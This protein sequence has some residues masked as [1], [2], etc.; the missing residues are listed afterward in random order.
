MGMCENQLY[1]TGTNPTRT[2]VYVTQSI[3]VFRTLRRSQS[4]VFKPNPTFRVLLR[5]PS[6]KGCVMGPTIFGLLPKD[7]GHLSFG[8]A[9][10]PAQEGLPEVHQPELG[11]CIL[12]LWAGRGM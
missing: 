6:E 12:H 5:T 3:G 8:D 7:E 4:V 1:P 10:S 9:A 11:A 2:E